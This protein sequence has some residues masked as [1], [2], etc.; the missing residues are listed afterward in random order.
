MANST[1]RDTSQ[2]SRRFGPSRGAERDDTRPP[3]PAKPKPTVATRRVTVR[4][5][6]TQEAEMRHG[7][8]RRA[9]AVVVSAML[10][11]GGAVGL[12]AA[13]ASAQTDTTE[14]TDTTA[15]PATADPVVAAQSTTTLPLFGVPLT[16]DVST[17]PSGSLADVAV[18]PAD[19]MTA[20]SVHPN[21]VTFVNDANAGEVRLE[22]RHGAERT[23]VVA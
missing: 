13:P 20:T 15:P 3:T 12:L 2:V 1:R 23:G 5:G 19:N 18:N 4:R 10:V 22:T 16:V 17:T 14:P 21:R 7:Y 8:R 11:G 9:C 6:R